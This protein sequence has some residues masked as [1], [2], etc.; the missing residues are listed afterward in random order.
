[1]RNRSASLYVAISMSVVA[2]LML[3]VG[4]F[5]G[6]LLLAPYI[7]GHAQAAESPQ[8]IEQGPP[9]AQLDSTGTDI[10]AAY[11]QALI[12]VYKDTLPSVVN[13][14]VTKSL[15]FSG[16]AHPPVEPDSDEPEGVRGGGSGF[17]WDKE[18][19][20][21]T[22][23]HVIAGATDVEVIFADD[24]R[25]KAEVVGSDPDADLAVIKVE[26]PA[27]SLQPVKL[28]NSD[29]L[30]VGQLS[31]AIGNP[32][33]QEFTMTSGI[34]SAVGR[35]IRS[36]R[37][38]FSIPEVIQTDA[39]INPGNSGGPLLTR[40]GEVIGINTQMLSRSG[41]SSGIGFAVPVNI[42]KRVVPTLIEGKA[43]EYSWLGVSG[44]NLSAEAIEFRNL[45]AET[46]GAVVITVIKDGPAAQAGLQGVD[47]S[48]E[49]DS[50]A[51]RFGGDIITAINS[52]PVN[53]MDDL[54]TYL[55]E[56]TNPGDEITLA[57]IRADGAEENVSVTLGVR[58]SAESL[59]LDDE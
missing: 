20:I 38:G 31:L 35:T 14:R 54:I 51:F 12:D 47:S 58:P 2:T 16:F 43:V 29:A 45:P 17:V 42:A 10:M 34:V 18:G 41:S 8:T 37:G 23:H 49:A 40:Q 57:V 21:V 25:V 11:E 9:A 26:L 56:E 24:T 36:G 28:G 55:V 44:N 48:L 30:Q 4:A 1:M 6:G 3:A 7:T 33:G 52:Q 59:S 5:A 46:R 19:H 50:D 53:D 39:P 27:G 22:N 15:D 13:I 32:F